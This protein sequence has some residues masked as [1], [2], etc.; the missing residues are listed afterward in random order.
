METAS[1]L[2]PLVVLHRQESSGTMK[3]IHDSDQISVAGRS[4]MSSIKGKNFKTLEMDDGLLHLNE[5]KSML[6]H[7]W[8]LFQQ[9]V[10]QSFNNRAQLQDFLKILLDV[11]DILRT[12][13][14]RDKFL[15]RESI[16]LSIDPTE[17]GFPLFVR[18]LHFLNKERKSALSNGNE[19]VSNKRLVD[20][21]LFSIFRGVF[22]ADIVEAKMTK[23]IVTGLRNIP[24]LSSIRFGEPV[25]LGHEEDN[26]FVVCVQ[27]LEENFNTPRFYAVHFKFPSA[28]PDGSTLFS[29]LREA[30]LK[31]TNLS[32]DRELDYMAETIEDILGIQVHLIQRIDVGPFY[33]RFT[34]NPDAVQELLSKGADTDS[35]MT[36]KMYSV[37]R[38]GESSN[39]KNWIKAWLSG[40]RH[41][42]HFSKTLVT[43]TFMILPHRLIQKAHYH[44]IKIDRH[45]KMFGLS[46]RGGLFESTE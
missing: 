39:K 34:E 32:I 17:S 20:D 29:E 1:E 5:L 4:T 22:P 15:D 11:T 45:V 7:M 28:S 16:D 24:E 46:D 8:M 44:N 12:R 30:F 27:R 26:H 43:P 21:A 19:N 37:H 18:D 38:I 13:M 42:G 25:Q 2:S 10:I 33:N 36:F 14:Q 31:C 9:D 35:I 23:N 41:L 3:R 40:D 6:A